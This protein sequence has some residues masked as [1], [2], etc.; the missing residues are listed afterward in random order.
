MLLLLFIRYLTA[1]TQSMRRS[2]LHDPGPH[3]A[4]AP[5]YAYGLHAPY[6]FMMSSCFYDSTSRCIHHPSA[7]AA[8]KAQFQASGA[9]GA[10]TAW[11]MQHAG[12]CTREQHATHI[13]CTQSTLQFGARLFCFRRHVQLPSAGHPVLDKT[14]FLH[15]ERGVKPS[16]H[17]CTWAH[18]AS[19]M[20]ARHS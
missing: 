9:I 20:H 4:T 13:V 12:V 16:M 7:V 17:A 14:G 5:V 19:T 18:V 15:K 1:C 2:C 11:C 8:A 10:H 6:A 3:A